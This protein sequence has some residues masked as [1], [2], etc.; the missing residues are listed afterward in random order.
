MALLGMQD[1]GVAFGGPPV[2][3]RANFGID[4]GERVCLLGRNGAGKSTVM[5]LLDRTMLPDSGEVVRQ[6]GVTVTRLEQEVPDD[7]E[8][9]TFEV[10]AA[11]LGPAGLLLSRY[12]DASHRVATDHSDSALRELDRLHHELDVA[13]AW[14]MQTGVDTVLQHLGLDP[15]APFAQASGGRKRQTLLA[16]AL[17]RQ[18]DVLLLDMQLPDGSGLSLLEDTAVATYASVVLMTGYASL[19][20]SIDALRMGAIDYLVKPVDSARLR[21]VLER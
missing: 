11:G 2:L 20:S 17:V 14:E 4:R 12:H 21:T 3:D 9:T 18:P 13:G 7:V 6:T 19:E 10:V 8:G 1:V 15:D 5:K 16:R